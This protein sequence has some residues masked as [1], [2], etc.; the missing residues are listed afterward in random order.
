MNT[1]FLILALLALG[2]VACKGKKVTEET[3]P[4]RSP[5]K[6]P[7]KVELPSEALGD[8]E[9][10]EVTAS[11]KS[12]HTAI[13]LAGNLSVW[14][15]LYADEHCQ[16]IDS[17]RERTVY[18]FYNFVDVGTTTRAKLME[19][20]M[21]IFQES[22]VRAF[23][24]QGACGHRNWIPKTNVDIL[25]EACPGVP[26]DNKYD[27]KFFSMR[28]DKGNLLFNETVMTRIKKQR[29]VNV[30]NVEV[31]N[32]T[33]SEVIAE[34]SSKTV[35]LV[36]PPS[37]EEMSLE[38]TSLTGPNMY[39]CDGLLNTH[40]S[41]TGAAGKIG[42]L[43]K[44]VAQEK[45]KLD[46][47]KLEEAREK[48]QLN[49]YVNQNNLGAY[50]ELMGEWDQLEVVTE[51]AIANLRVCE[52]DCQELQAQIR[53]LKAQKKD[54]NSRFA[55][56]RTPRHL[57]NGY[58]SHYNAIERVR[59]QMGKQQEKINE[60]EQAVRIAEDKL[61]SQFEG[62]EKAEG[63]P[64]QVRFHGSWSDNLAALIKANPKLKFRRAPIKKATLS[65]ALKGLT[66]YPTQQSI[67]SLPVPDQR[68]LVK[69]RIE[70]NDYPALISGPVRLS[71]LAA[72]PA[73]DPKAWGVT[74]KKPN[75]LE[76]VLNWTYER[77]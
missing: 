57:E 41:S 55:A 8:W 17:T 12:V 10:C 58:Y 34:G 54:L 27:L 48:D 9:K 30:E 15:T 50:H 77:K 63:A 26:R 11:G 32:P 1:K 51:T 44:L 66:N 4:G 3:P 2:T 65:Y 6:Q 22:E 73:K 7:E 69:G 16:R 19:R 47:L 46:E 68:L 62:Y 70:F 14:E 35:K 43:R 42:D 21:A 72:C 40:I 52:D 59:A 61:L 20:K 39:L 76:Y 18:S 5:V 67:L 37:T 25:G 31:V 64:G 23:N 28:M 56:L 74:L 29:S 53:E 75:T 45:K 36:F 38:V 71:I 13:H 49:A 60:R 24:E 33:T